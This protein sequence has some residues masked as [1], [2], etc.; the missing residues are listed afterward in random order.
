M[1]E[2]I[3]FAAQESVTIYYDM[4]MTLSDIK[5]YIA[6]N[7]PMK[8]SDDTPV[9]AEELMKIVKDDVNGE[10]SDIQVTEKDYSEPHS[11]LESFTQYMRDNIYDYESDRE[12]NDGSYEDEVS[13]ITE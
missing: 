11:M 6:A 9:T 10:D 5:D 12:T 13:I 1:E 4:D 7:H 3:H 2:K 8:V